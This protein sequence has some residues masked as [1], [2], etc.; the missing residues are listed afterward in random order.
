MKTD[1]KNT[2]ETKSTKE[3]KTNEGPEGKNISPIL[4]RTF[5]SSFVSSFSGKM[6][7]IDFVPEPNFRFLWKVSR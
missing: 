4:L 2:K 7:D 1:T 6:D 3:K 5:L